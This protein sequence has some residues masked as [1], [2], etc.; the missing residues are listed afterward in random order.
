MPVTPA[1]LANVA[2]ALCCAV[3]LLAVEPGS[4]GTPPSLVPF[5]VG[6]TTVRSVSTPAGD[7]ESLRVIT[8]IDPKG[9]SI[10]ASA[11][12]PSDDGSELVKVSVRRRVLT[13]DQAGSRRMRNY[14]HDD[15]DDVFPGTVPGVSAAV[16]SDLRNS[17]TAAFTYLDVGAF[18]GGSVIKGEYSGTLARL[19]D[20]VTTIPVWV[21]GRMI[22]LPIIHAKGLLTGTHRQKAFEYYLL[23]DPANPIVL[24][25]NGNG[26]V[27]AITRIEYP[28]VKASPSSLESA[29]SKNEV[30][31]VYGIYFSFNR[32]DLRPESDRTLD[33][34]AAI[35][36]AHPQW[37]LRIDG[38]TDGVGAHAA[39]LD[40][41]RRRSAAVKD[42]LVTRYHIDGGRLT[43]SGYGDT[44]P[45]ATN[46]TPEGRSRNR[47]VELRRE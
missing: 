11:E 45:Q 44:S 23:D 31:E 17:G 20:S 26:S 36:K 21:N 43:A 46:D 2:V 40:L 42:A 3:P 30:A 41:S 16:I 8:A 15:D 32:S 19:K 33:D 10:I 34:I 18:F 4:H 9:Y 29:L 5:V 12:V 47:R 14:F 39:N 25:A 6:L 24:R 1:L 35:L 7:Y 27:N 38:H 22:Q 13:A 28:E 37:K